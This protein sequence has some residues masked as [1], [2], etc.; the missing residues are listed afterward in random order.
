LFCKKK[1]IGK[2][3]VFRAVFA[4]F[5][6]T[7]KNPFLS[8][9]DLLDYILNKRT[10]MRKFSLLFLLAFFACTKTELTPGIIQPTNVFDANSTAGHKRII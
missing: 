2:T 3:D 5:S 10:I 4:N 9:K 6:D 7:A 8:Q 1:V